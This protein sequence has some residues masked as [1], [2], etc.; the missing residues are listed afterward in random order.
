MVYGFAPFVPLPAQQL[1]QHHLMG[2]PSFDN[3][4]HHHNGPNHGPTMNGRGDNPSTSPSLVDNTSGGN[5]YDEN[6]MLGWS[7]CGSST[8]GTEGSIGGG[9]GPSSHGNTN[10][11]H[12]PNTRIT[13]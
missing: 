5:S 4:N 2:I 8:D 12:H 13:L 7:G 11:I 10:P 1:Q 6:D 9:Y 3:N